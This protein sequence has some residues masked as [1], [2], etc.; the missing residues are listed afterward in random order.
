[1]P[2]FGDAARLQRAV[3][4]LL[5][6]AIKFGAEGKTVGV[7]AGRSDKA[8]LLTVADRGP[9][10]A[11]DRQEKIFEPFYQVDGSITREHGGVGLGLAIARRTARG[12][13]GN[14][15]VLS[16]AA[17]HIGG[18][19]FAGA[20]FVLEVAERAPNPEVPAAR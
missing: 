2:A 12:L 6:N 17:E 11:A 18:E 3:G 14:V 10:V 16:P 8:Y 19:E 5:D 15:F 13:G 4:H 9:G 1:M 20:A 7:R